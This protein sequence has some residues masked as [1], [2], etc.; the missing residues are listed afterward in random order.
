MPPVAVISP[1]SQTVKLP[2]TGAVLDGS[3]SSDDDKIVSW[4]WELQQGPLGFQPHLQDTSTLQ[5]DNLVVPGNYTF[6]WVLGFD[7]KSW[8]DITYSYKHAVDMQ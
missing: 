6:K 2:N 1:S 3:S 4:H 7:T 5:L 8:Q